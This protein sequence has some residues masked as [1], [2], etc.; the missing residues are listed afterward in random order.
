MSEK[1]RK[2]LLDAEID[3]LQDDPEYIAAGL[4]IE[5]ADRVFEQMKNLGMTQ[6]QLAKQ[7]GCSQ[8]YISRILNHGT[9]MS[10]LTLARIAVALDMEIQPVLLAPKYLFRESFKILYFNRPRD[11]DEREYSKN[12]SLNRLTGGEN[13]SITDAA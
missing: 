9:S 6:K 12:D 10:L 11:Y 1:Q 4:M 5:I 2:G 3:S 13:E 8:P 7:I